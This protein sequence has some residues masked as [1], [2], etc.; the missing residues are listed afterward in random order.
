MSKKKKQKYR[1]LYIMDKN[2]N[3]IDNTLGQ[4]HSSGCVRMSVENSQWFYDNIEY[5]T[6]VCI[7]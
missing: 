3:V 4:K 6:G 7:Y 1:I 2:K 5:G